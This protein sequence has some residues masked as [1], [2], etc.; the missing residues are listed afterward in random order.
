MIALTLFFCIAVSTFAEERYQAT[1]TRII[2]GDTL[3][4]W[5]GEAEY[6]VRLIGIDTP[7]T[8]PNW[9]AEKDAADWGVSVEDVTRAGGK[10]RIFVASIAPPGLRVGLVAGGEDA[11]G[12]TL[13]YVH[14]PGGRCLNEIIVSV[15]CAL[16]PS[17]YRH[18]RQ[19]EFAAIE[20]EA[21]GAGGA[22]GKRY[23]KENHHEHPEHHPA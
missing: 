4:V 23:G 14:L 2:D 5:D 3:R 22:F 11:Y 21:R 6:P 9:K 1:I 8:R 17:R 18:D 15:G 16:A 13:A 12:R 10:A 19:S 20:R 7:E